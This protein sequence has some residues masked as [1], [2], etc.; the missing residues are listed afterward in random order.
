MRPERGPSAVTGQRSEINP[1]GRFEVFYEGL[2]EFSVDLFVRAEVHDAQW[3]GTVRGPF[4]ATARTLLSTHEFTPRPPGDGTR[5][6]ARI[7]DPCFWSGDSP[8]LYR[9]DVEIM[10]GGVSLGSWQTQIG[11]RALSAARGGVYWSRRRVVLRGVDHRL[12]VAQGIEAWRAASA[13]LYA[14]DPCGALLGATSRGGVAVMAEIDVDRDDYLDV[15]QCCARAASV[16][17]IVVDCAND[18]PRG[19]AVRQVARNC[20]LAQRWTPESSSSPAP[21]ADLVIGSV[22]DP[23]RFAAR[24]SAV[25]VP[26]LAER[27]IEG[28]HELHHARALCDQLQRDL[29][30]WGDYS[31]YLITAAGGRE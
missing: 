8:A 4:C 10:R 13:A 28:P 22:D 11:F 6:V 18:D 14:P 23:A 21:W 17:V 30:P 5:A 1:P 9:L 12:A 2:T 26:V 27:R 16:L 3:R 7:A 24:Y 20:L 31:G 19:G 25:G 15:A 29:A